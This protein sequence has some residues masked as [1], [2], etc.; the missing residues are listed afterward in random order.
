MG[1]VCNTVLLV[2]ESKISEIYN[3][4]FG[5]TRHGS[6]YSKENIRVNPK[7]RRLSLSYSNNDDYI[8]FAKMWKEGFI[9]TTTDEELKTN[10][11]E[12]QIEKCKNELNNLLKKLEELELCKNL[13]K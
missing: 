1:R 3:G 6:I 5:F 13:K 9:E 7:N 10:T 2:K 8:L 12:R 4:R 11:T